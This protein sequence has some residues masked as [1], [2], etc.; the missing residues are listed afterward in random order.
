MRTQRLKLDGL[1]IRYSWTQAQEGRT[2]LL[3]LNGVGASL[4][5]AES[6]LV[7]LA[8]QGLS[9][10]SLDLPGIGGSSFRRL[11]GRM[12]G[13]ADLVKQVLDALDISQVHVMGYSW[14]G[15]LAQHFSYRHGAYVRCLVLACTGPGCLMVPGWPGAYLAFLNPL[16]YRPG[17][18]AKVAGRKR[19]GK[20]VGQAAETGRLYLSGMALQLAAGMGW[21]SAHWLRRLT[22]PT[23]VIGGER[24]R[25]VPPVNARW[26][27]RAIPDAQLFLVR[28]GSH[29]CAFTHAEVVSG[30][31]ARHVAS[32]P[33]QE[34][35]GAA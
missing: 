19:K 11:P 2:P 24:D 18:V 31:V 25:L 1:T 26:L 12:S 30:V 14:G 28:G 7:A 6:L 32:H 13:Y 8:A 9:T 21:T 15:A 10:L 23:L 3:L 22:V 29:L 4:E 35:R 34:S 17:G 27:A 5:T 20:D 33:R 16:L